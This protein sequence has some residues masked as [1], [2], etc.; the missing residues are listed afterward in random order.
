MQVQALGMGFK[1]QGIVADEA[2][3]DH[4]HFLRHEYREITVLFCVRVEG[5]MVDAL[6]IEVWLMGNRVPGFAQ[7][8]A[9]SG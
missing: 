1:D 4:H 6:G 5:F 7:G 3:V 8:F 2:G 9:F